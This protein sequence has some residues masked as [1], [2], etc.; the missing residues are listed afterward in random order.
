MWGSLLSLHIPLH[1]DSNWLGV[2]RAYA[3]M[4]GPLLGLQIG[5]AQPLLRQ[6]ASPALCSV[7]LALQFLEWCT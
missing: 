2:W 5:S 1:A 6:E 3:P 7:C 4:R